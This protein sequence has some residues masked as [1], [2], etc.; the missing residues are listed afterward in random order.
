MDKKDARVRECL[1]RVSGGV[2]GDN[3]VDG[4]VALN[5]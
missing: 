5:E 2:F 3:I 4:E 1:S